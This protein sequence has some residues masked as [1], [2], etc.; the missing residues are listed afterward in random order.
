MSKNKI[1]S[2]TVPTSEEFTKTL[3]QI[4]W[5]M[6]LSKGHRD[7]K[8]NQIEPRILAPLMMKQVRVFTK[9][10]QPLAAI[11]WAYV[12]DEVEAKIAARSSDL[13]LEDW[14]SGKKVVIVDCISPL[15]DGAIFKEQFMSQVNSLI[16]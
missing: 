1:R 12:S 4:T 9:G 11:T 5:L 14:R 16:K 13:T 10:T 2:T 7:M 15:M 3:G 8:V 6:T